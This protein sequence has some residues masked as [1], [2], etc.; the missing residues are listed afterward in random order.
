MSSRQEILLQIGKEETPKL[1]EA[2]KQGQ[3][4]LRA[5]VWRTMDRLEPIADP[6]PSRSYGGFSLA[7]LAPVVALLPA[8]LVAPFGRAFQRGRPPLAIDERALEGRTRQEGAPPFSPQRTIFRTPGAVHHLTMNGGDGISGTD[9]RRWETAI[10]GPFVD[11]DGPYLLA[12]FSDT[13]TKK[14]SAERLPSLVTL[15][16]AGDKAWASKDGAITLE[17]QILGLALNLKEPYR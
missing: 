12:A 1:V 9:R 6:V 10:E 17:Q 15:R 14:P 2:F 13:G 5:A 4:T 16:P 7:D 3:D 11:K 8:E